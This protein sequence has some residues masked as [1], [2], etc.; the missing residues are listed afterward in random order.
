MR[1][2]HRM[3]ASLRLCRVAGAA[4]RLAIVWLYAVD[5]DL[6]GAVL[7]PL[8]ATGTSGDVER[9]ILAAFDRGEALGTA[10]ESSGRV[11]GAARVGGAI[12]CRAGR[13]TPIGG[14]AAF[15][16][17]GVS[18]VNALIRQPRSNSS[19]PPGQRGR[20]AYFRRLTW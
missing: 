1:A 17:A 15:G 3:P 13:S 19:D 18:W 12:Q 9:L 16:A 8:D 20:R 2:S 10:L 14:G 7:E 11:G 5:D 6:L 4:G